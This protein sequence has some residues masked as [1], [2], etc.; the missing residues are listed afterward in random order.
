MCPLN[1]SGY[2]YVILLYS[3]FCTCLSLLST[4]AFSA[5]QKLKQAGEI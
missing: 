2:F 3:N 4:I 5:E 1:A